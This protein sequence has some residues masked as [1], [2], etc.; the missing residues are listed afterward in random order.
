MRH[1]ER[2]RGAGPAH[3]GFGNRET[4]WRGGLGLRL[5]PDDRPRYSSLSRRDRTA[6]LEEVQ[7]DLEQMSA[8]IAAELRRLQREEAGAPT[9]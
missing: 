5:S 6:R 9:S 8:D 4:G 2:G 1:R 7:R 3:R